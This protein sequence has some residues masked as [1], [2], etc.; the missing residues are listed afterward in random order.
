M[1]PMPGAGTDDG[2]P[3]ARGVRAAATWFGVGATIAVVTTLAIV[4]LTGR[5][6]PA[7]SAEASE[8]AAATADE[9]MV[10]ERIRRL[11]G[12]V[13][14]LDELAR[15]G[16][17][18]DPS[19]LPRADRFLIAL[20]H[21]ENIVATSRP[22]QR[23]LQLVLDLAANGQIARPLIE[24]LGSH[25]ARGL[26][27]EAEL[28]ERFMGLSA[29]IAARAPR[30]GGIVQRTLGSL[31][32]T[33]A[34][35]G[36]MAPPAPGATEAALQSVAERL[37]RGDLAGAVTEVTMLGEEHQPLLAGWLAQARARLAVEHAIRETMLHALSPGTRPG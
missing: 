36:L 4:T 11:E 26:P 3:A 32:A 12:Q 34:D 37:R 13:A 19:A 14:R 15:R 24:V 30:E 35:I 22:W 28:R 16:T 1:N 17:Q 33:L 6:P 29:S 10:A 25:A 23:D 7:V 27:T 31:R 5:P 8:R 2:K 21:L 20:L 9:T 18:A